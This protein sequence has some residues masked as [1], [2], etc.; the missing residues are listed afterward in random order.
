M[1]D[2][3]VI[4]VGGVLAVVI[5]LPATY[6]FSYMASRAFFDAKLNYQRLLMGGFNRGAENGQSTEE[7]K[8]P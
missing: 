7:Q 1:S 6:S 8:R 4:V 5:G 3:L 2:Y